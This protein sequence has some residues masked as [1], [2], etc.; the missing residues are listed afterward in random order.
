M[1]KIILILPILFL[2]SAC[3]QQTTRT[4]SP[5]YGAGSSAYTLEALDA[6]YQLS[7]DN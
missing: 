3:T 7:R 6:R 4:L 2:L 5:N 1:L